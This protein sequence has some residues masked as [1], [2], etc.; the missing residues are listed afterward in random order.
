MTRRD[1]QQ[2]YSQPAL[3][4]IGGATGLA[5]VL[6]AWLLDLEFLAGVATAVVIGLLMSGLLRWRTQGSRLREGQEG[7]ALTET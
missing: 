3:E 2:H 1:V 7:R 6:V 5:V 4:L